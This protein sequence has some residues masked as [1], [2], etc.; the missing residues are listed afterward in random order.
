MTEAL[1]NAVTRLAKAQERQTELASDGRADGRDVAAACQDRDVFLADVV[2]LG[3]EHLRAM[4]EI[5]P[6]SVPDF[7]DDDDDE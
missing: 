2:R 4:R 1:D 6:E 3:L 7:G 5:D